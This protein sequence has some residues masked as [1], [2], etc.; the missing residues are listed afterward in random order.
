M[1]GE[2]KKMVGEIP[3]SKLKLLILIIVTFIISYLII[4][5]MLKIGGYRW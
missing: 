2:S 5:L 4:L 3:V 1:N